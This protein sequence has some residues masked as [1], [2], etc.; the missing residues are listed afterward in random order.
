MSSCVNCRR[1]FLLKSRAQCEAQS[2]RDA[3]AAPRP[4][5]PRPIKPIFA[6]AGLLNKVVSFV[7]IDSASPPERT[8]LPVGNIRSS[9]PAAM[10]DREEMPIAT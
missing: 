2:S 7:Q 10:L 5:T 9:D 8:A 6:T 4:I 3:E 1:Q